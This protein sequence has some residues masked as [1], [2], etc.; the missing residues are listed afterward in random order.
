MNN[1]AKKQDTKKENHIN[2][3]NDE[4]DNDDDIESVTANVVTHN[5]DQ[6]I[7]SISKQLNSSKTKQQMKNNYYSVFIDEPTKDIEQDTMNTSNDCETKTNNSERK[8]ID[9]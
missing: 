8:N 4:D 5:S 2:I 7:K 1:I 6:E 9:G 3:N